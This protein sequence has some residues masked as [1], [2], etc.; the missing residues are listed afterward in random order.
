MPHGNVVLTICL[1]VSLLE[2]VEITSGKFVILSEIAHHV[3]AHI[4]TPTVN[5]MKKNCAALCCKVMKWRFM[6]G[7]RETQKCITFAINYIL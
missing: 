3:H 2:K 7:A 1:C 4:H 5:S 6:G